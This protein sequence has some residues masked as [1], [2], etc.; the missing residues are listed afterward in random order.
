MR[1]R[2]QIA[3]SRFYRP[4][5]RNQETHLPIWKRD[6]KV[7]VVEKRGRINH[8]QKKETISIINILRK[9]IRVIEKI[10]KGKIIIN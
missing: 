2:N 3:H 6:L 4:S 9:R 5:N 7:K 1:L 10:K 8:L